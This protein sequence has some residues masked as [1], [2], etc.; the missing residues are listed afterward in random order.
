MIRP[1]L[2]PGRRGSQDQNLQKSATQS[3]V[4]GWA[5]AD[6]FAASE[7]LA[8]QPAGPL[9]EAA[10]E[11]LIGALS[12]NAPEDAL[13]WAATLTDPQQR[14]SQQMNILQNLIW[15]DTQRAKTLAAE[16][17][18]SEPMRKSLDQMIESRE[19]GSY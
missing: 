9:R 2:S 11:G 7:W 4:G 18:F 10:V 1:A 17:S 19:K 8:D 5:Q 14:E 12:Y 6:A 16:L 3:A 13:E 15:R